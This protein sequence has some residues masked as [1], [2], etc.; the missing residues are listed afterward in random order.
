MPKISLAFCLVLSRSMFVL[1]SVFFWPLSVIRFKASDYLFG[2][3]IF[4][5]LISADIE[6]RN[7]IVNYRISY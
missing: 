6:F 3:L 2:I 1:L 7:I 5:Y 4:S